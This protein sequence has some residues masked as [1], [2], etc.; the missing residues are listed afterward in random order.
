[1]HPTPRNRSTFPGAGV[2]TGHW[3]GDTSISWQ[4]LRESTA[5]V[6]NANMWGLAMTGADICGYGALGLGWLVCWL[7]G[8][9]VRWWLVWPAG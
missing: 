1:M 5:S 6:L 7:V 8:W 2:V 9:V 3:T 4:A